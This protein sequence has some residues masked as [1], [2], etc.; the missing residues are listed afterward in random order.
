MFGRPATEGSD[1]AGDGKFGGFDCGFDAVMAERLAGNGSDG[2]RCHGARPRCNVGLAQ[3]LEEI[4]YGGRTGECDHVRKAA[5]RGKR[6]PQGFSG[7]SRDHSLIGID[8][9]H[10]RSRIA[11]LVRKDIASDP[12]AH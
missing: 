8:D 2:G 9:I 11:K 3:Q 12:G 4:G 6:Q 5:G 10:T 1:Q 7:N